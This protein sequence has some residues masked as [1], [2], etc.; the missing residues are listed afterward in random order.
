MKIIEGNTGAQD[1]KDKLI[2]LIEDVESI[3]MQC[4]PVT[5]KLLF[6]KYQDEVEDYKYWASGYDLLI[7]ALQNEIDTD[8][9]Y[10]TFLT[11]LVD[12]PN[13]TTSVFMVIIERLA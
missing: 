7:A 8:G 3:P 9:E 6:G 5:A 4:N 12:P 10:K 2:A 13:N 11:G 1:R